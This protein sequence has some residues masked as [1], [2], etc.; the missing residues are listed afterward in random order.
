MTLRVHLAAVVFLAALS[1]P[2]RAVAQTDANEIP[3]GDV[4]RAARKSAALPA[5]TVIDNDN[6]SD[7]MDEVATRRLKGNLLV[8]PDKGGQT[9][10]ISAPDVTCNLSFNSQFSS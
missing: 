10:R 8:S 6:L 9:L 1:F 2:F 3:L 4:A 5:H 7:V